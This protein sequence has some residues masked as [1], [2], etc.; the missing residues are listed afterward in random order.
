MKQKDGK[1]KEEEKREGKEFADSDR[2]LASYNI[3]L[4]IVSISVHVFFSHKTVS[5]M[6]PKRI[7]FFHEGRECTCIFLPTIY[8]LPSGGVDAINDYIEHQERPKGTYIHR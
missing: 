8:L 7:V 3:S 1:R 4:I 5:I 2:I 6:Q